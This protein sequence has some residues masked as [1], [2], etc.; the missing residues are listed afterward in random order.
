MPTITIEYYHDVD[1]NQPRAYEKFLYRM[2]QFTGEEGYAV[3]VVDS[4]TF[5]ELAAR[6]REEKIINPMEKFGKGTD[7]RQWF[8]GSTDALEEMLIMRLGGLAMNVVVISHIDERRNEVSGE[9]L[10]GPFAPGRLSKRGLL[11]AAY[12][13]QYH[14]FAGR[15]EDGKRFYALQTVNDGMWAATTQIEAPDP[16][17]PTYDGIFANRP[18]LK[19]KPMHVLVYGDTGTGKSTFAQTFIACGNMIVWCFDPYG[20]DLPYQK[21]G[22]VGELSYYEIAVGTGVVQIPYRQIEF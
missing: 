12:Q 9:I 15:G 14:T 6:K 8:S 13:E 16:S 21:G 7:T 5:M 10:R 17:F 4:A 20:K 18:D 19:F 3:G 22:K 11:C 1:P 2:G